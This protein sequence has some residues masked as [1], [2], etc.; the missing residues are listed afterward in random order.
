MRAWIP[1]L[2]FQHYRLGSAVVMPTQGTQPAIEITATGATGR[3][4]RVPGPWAVT[5]AVGCG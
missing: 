2:R 3:K 1:T 5:P 4:G